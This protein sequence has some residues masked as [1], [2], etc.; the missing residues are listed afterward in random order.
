[1]LICFSVRTLA[2]HQITPKENVVHCISFFLFLMLKGQKIQKEKMVYALL[3]R[4]LSPPFPF[5]VSP[6]IAIASTEPQEMLEV[7]R[8]SYLASPSRF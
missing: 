8:N 4:Y 2:V 1:M 3:F 5:Q 6:G 7:F